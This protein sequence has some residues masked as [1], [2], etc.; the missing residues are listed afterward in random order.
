MALIDDVKVALR[1]TDSATPTALEL[2]RT[3]DI[4]NTIDAAKKDLIRSGWIE[5]L[6]IDTDVRVIEA[7]KLYAKAIYDF[8][9]KGQI[10]MDRYRLYRDA[11]VLDT[12]Y[13]EPP[14][15]GDEDV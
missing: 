7:V 9:G 2:A 8:Q 5:S 6:V 10:Y 3:N 13:N 14:D 15:G 1:I 4:T 11:N 12:A